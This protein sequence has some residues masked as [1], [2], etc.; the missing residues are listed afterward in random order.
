[1]AIISTSKL[2][3]DGGQSAV[4]QLTG[5]CDGS[6]N[7][8]LV[9]AVDVPIMNF[10]VETVAI[11]GLNWDVNGGVVNLYWDCEDPVLI[12]TLSTIGHDDYTSFGGIQN[13]AMPQ[14]YSDNVYNVTINAVSGNI[15]LSTIGFD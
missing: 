2:L 3:Y 8:T 15:L 7:D 6:S 9:T 13:S 10:N 14:S 1:M 4:V 12:K 11:R 5:L